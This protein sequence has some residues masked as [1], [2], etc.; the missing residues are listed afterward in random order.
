M[1]QPIDP[2]IERKVL[3]IFNDIWYDF[4]EEEGMINKHQ[5][6][7]IMRYSRDHA[8]YKPKTTETDPFTEAALD[9]AYDKEYATKYRN[10][11]PVVGKIPHRA[12]L[13]MAAE[14]FEHEKQ[15]KE[16]KAQRI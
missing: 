14:I 4:D 12:V 9:R 16:A 1:R 8:G 3:D 13:H 5:F 6:K 11:K 10:E 7:Q 15:R 2:K